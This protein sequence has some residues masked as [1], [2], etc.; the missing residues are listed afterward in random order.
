MT[1]YI[2]FL[3]YTPNPHFFKTNFSENVP[4]HV[5]YLILYSKLRTKINK[6]GSDER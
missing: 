1:V 2:K 5:Y 6:A 3:T 4:S